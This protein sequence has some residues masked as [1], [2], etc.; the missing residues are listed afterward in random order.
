MLVEVEKDTYLF[1]PLPRLP[2]SSKPCKLSDFEKLSR[3]PRTSGPF[4]Y[5]PLHDLESIVWVGLWCVFG[6]AAKPSGA[7]V[8]SYS[9]KQLEAQKSSSR[10]V[11]NFRYSNLRNPWN[12]AAQAK[13]C[14]TEE[15]GLYLIDA[16]SEKHT[17]RQKKMQ[18]GSIMQCT[19]EPMRKSP[20]FLDTHKKHFLI[21]IYAHFRNYQGY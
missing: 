17:P 20:S 3:P 8:Y 11:C 4:I 5:N 10:M 14:V 9:Y 12:L 19:L 6:H 7:A 16:F 21:T 13:A 1:Q 15:Y 18:Q 2:E